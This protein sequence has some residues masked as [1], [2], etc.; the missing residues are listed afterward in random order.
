VVAL[1]RRERRLTLA[2]GSALYYEKLALA[3]G[4][5]PRIPAIAGI[6]LDGVYYLR[7]AE[8]A[9]W[10]RSRLPHA[11]GVVVIGGG[12]IGLEIAATARLLGKAVTVLEAADRL[13]GRVV[14]PEIS[15]HFRVLHEGWGSDLRF[16]TPVGAIVGEGGKVVAVETAAGERIPADV[17]VIGI[18]V[19]PNIEMAASAGLAAEN[20][21]L[22]DQFMTTSDP[23][24]VSI[25]DCV[26]FDHW[27]LG[28]RVRLESVQNAVDQ[29]KTAALTLLGKPEPYRAVPWFWSDQGDA[30]LQMV[31]LSADADR[32]VMR[33][34]PES[35]AFS[36]FHFA[37]GRLVAIDSVNKPADHM[38]GRRMIGAGASPPPELVADENADLKALLGERTAAGH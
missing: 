3:L 22:V 28:R 5:R 13:M 23:S 1:D 6:D 25:G 7:N 35:G 18:G 19:L 24:I 29:G 12:F 11:E 2:D 20:G 21:I 37:G 32:S 31:G 9:R 34:N 26:A 16:K 17:A 30:K 15:Q 36:V 38:V 33:G 10:L 8:D 14:H 4:S 27:A